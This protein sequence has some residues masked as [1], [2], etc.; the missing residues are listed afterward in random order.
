MIASHD[1]AAVRAGHH[2]VERGERPHGEV[3]VVRQ[4]PEAVRQPRA[5]VVRDREREQ[6]L[7][8]G[9]AETGP[10]RPVGRRE[11]DEQL[12]ERERE[13]TS[14]PRSPAT[15]IADERADEQA[16]EAVDVLDREARPAP[17]LRLAA[18]RHSEQTTTVS[19]TYAATPEA[20]AAYQIA[21]L[22]LTCTLHGSARPGVV[23]DDLAV[24]ARRNGP[25]C[26]ARR[27]TRARPSPRRNATFAATSAA[28]QLAPDAVTCSHGE[29]LGAPVRGSTRCAPREAVPLVARPPATTR[30]APPCRQRDVDRAA[31]RDVAAGRDE[32]SARRAP[33][34]LR[35]RRVP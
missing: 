2:A 25:G 4:P 16:A 5:V 19:T 33:P 30:I 21:G 17:A 32:A 3:E 18:H 13:D 31:H 1:R 9:D 23:L 27:A 35:R 20:R 34:P 26:R 10:E 7:R 22:E 11:R 28:R 24:A 12:R 15:W 8:G 29:S 6:Q 14:R